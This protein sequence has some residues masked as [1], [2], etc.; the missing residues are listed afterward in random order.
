MTAIQRLPAEAIAQIKSSATIPT[1]GAAAIGLLKNSLDAGATRV[2][3]LVDWTRGDCTVEDDGAGIP[4]AEFQAS[5]GLGKQWCRLRS[6]A[7]A[8][9][10]GAIADAGIA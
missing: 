3:V 1:L 10:V 4:A 7:K 8:S 2:N 5:G 6:A 9:C